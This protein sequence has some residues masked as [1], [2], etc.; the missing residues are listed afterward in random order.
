MSALTVR[1]GLSNELCA[2][3]EVALA[4]GCVGRD[5]LDGWLASLHEERFESE[6]SDLVEALGTVAVAM[7]VPNLDGA[8]PHG[9]PGQGR[10]SRRYLNELDRYPTMDRAQEVAGAKRLEF[11]LERCAAAD[12]RPPSIRAARRTEYQLAFNEFVERNLH[13]VVSEVYSYRTYA[14]PLDDLVQEGNAALMHAV[15]KFDW[16][17][18]V[19]FRTYVAW[20]IRQAVERHLASAKGAVRVP[21]HL[22]QKLR[23][24]K[25]QGRLPGGFDQSTSVADVAAAFEVDH[26]QAGHL[27]ESSRASMSLEQEVDDGGERFRDLLAA[28]WEPRDSDRDQNLKNRISHLLTELEPREQTVLRLRFGLDGTKA[29]TLEEIGSALHLS[30]ERSRQ[31]QQAALIKLRARAGSTCLE[32][33][34]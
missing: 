4:H 23:R 11:A 30:R 29:K 10:I 31:I 14:V 24:L 2:R 19:R 7:T 32:D 18:G 13:I 16:R 26:E 6:L 5:E 3:L 9:L 15:E 27:V 22:Q 21:H 17:K 33:E 34:I 12:F 20:W 28:D 25:R 1:S 8:P